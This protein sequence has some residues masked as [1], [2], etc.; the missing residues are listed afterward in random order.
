MKCPKCN[1]EM[2]ITKNRRI[3]SSEEQKLYRDMEFSCR[4]KKCPNFEKVVD[5]QR[6]ELECFTE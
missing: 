2:I 3:F 4:N 5:T 6:T 1:T